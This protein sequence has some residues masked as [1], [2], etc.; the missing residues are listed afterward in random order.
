MEN[1]EN[2]YVC[3]WFSVGAILCFL[4][5]HCIIVY[6]LVYEYMNTYFCILLN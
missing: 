5:C 6:S 2:V 3:L 1:V 4:L